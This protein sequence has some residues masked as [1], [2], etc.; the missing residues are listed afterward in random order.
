MAEEHTSYLTA[1]DV[2]RACVYLDVSTGP[3]AAEAPKPLTAADITADT[4]IEVFL[5]IA[6][7]PTL[8]LI[9][10]LVARAKTVGKYRLIDWLAPLQ[11]NTKFADGPAFRAAFKHLAVIHG[12]PKAFDD[13]L[14]MLG[15]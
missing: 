7:A 8:Q 9:P 10:E 6:T 4:P 2:A 3:S 5:R 14:A 15:L 13:K 12:Q 1:A 11:W